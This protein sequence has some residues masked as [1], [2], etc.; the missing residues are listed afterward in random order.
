MSGLTL[1]AKGVRLRN[2]EVADVRKGS[3]GELAGIRAGD[4]LISIDGIPT[5]EFNLNLL[6]TALDIREGKRLRVELLR[7]GKIIKTK[8]VLMN[9]I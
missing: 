9:Q 3:S 5:A 7:G 8:L 4:Q 6:N 2:F 1:K